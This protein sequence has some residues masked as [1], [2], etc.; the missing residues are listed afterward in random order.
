MKN[1]IQFLN[2][3]QNNNHRE[4]FEDHRAEYKEAQSVFNIYVEKLISGIASFDP[5]IKNL[6]VKDCTY[7]IY[8]DIRFSKD[9]TPYKTHMGAFVAPNGKSGGYSGYYF[10]IEA[11]DANYI[12]SHLLSTG[13]YCPDPKVI[14][15]IREE[16]MLNGENFSEAVNIARKFTLDSTSSLKRVP[17]G[18]PSDSVYV[19]YF[20]LK[21]YFLSQRVD[22]AFLLKD[23]LLE[24]TIEEFKKTLVFNNLINRAAKYAYDLQ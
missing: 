8:R 4:W 18:F 20:K 1:I 7:R 22:D 2:Q 12:G 19:E 13:I 6:S 14:K 9:K 15:S 21:D 24:N 11:Q 10:H 17:A 5:L 3:L 23:N 16:I